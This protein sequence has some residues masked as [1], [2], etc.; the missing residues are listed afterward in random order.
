MFLNGLS[1]SIIEENIF[2]H[3]G[4]YQQR[5]SNVA[6]N[7][8][9][10]GY[11]TFF[12]HNVYIA[13]SSN[14]I[15]ERNLSSRSSS[16]GMKFTSN[17]NTTTKIDTINSY[18]ILL[19]NNI[20]VEGEVG[21]SIGG[22]KDFN[23]GYRWDNIQVINNVLTNIGRT[24]PTNRDLAFNIDV[25]DWQ[26]GVVCGNTVTD[27]AANISNTYGLS[28]AGHTRDLTIKNNSFINLGIA[29]DKSVLDSAENVTGS[30]NTY[31]SKVDDVN[32]LDMFVT[33][34]GFSDYESYITSVLSNLKNNPATYYDVNKFINY[35]NSSV[36]NEKQI[37]KSKE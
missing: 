19:K 6:M 7:T 24:R 4:W 3:N 32:F 10:Y 21:F 36:A 23:N 30:N 1:G 11:A 29:Q 14:L 31:I 12:N 16:I 35:I 13:D 18:N 34:H 26:S 8:K 33:S 15:I 28:V 25:N 5:P 20:I 37:Y 9:D 17:S 27:N 2:D 22:N